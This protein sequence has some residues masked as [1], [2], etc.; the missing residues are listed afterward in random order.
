MKGQSAMEFLATYG[1]MILAMLIAVGALAYYNVFSPSKFFPDECELFDRVTCTAAKVTNNPTPQLQ[2]VARNEFGQLLNP[3]N[4]TV[5]STEGCNGGYGAATGGLTDGEEE[6]I[7]V[8]CTNTLP[9]EG[10]YRA[11]LNISYT[12]TS[13][14]AHNAYGKIIAHIE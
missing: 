10:N 2:I 3:F 8:I 7:T 1:W 4:I 6:K 11:T 13:G 12:A 14:I 5:V 9:T